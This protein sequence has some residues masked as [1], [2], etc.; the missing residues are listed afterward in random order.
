M[1]I[2]MVATALRSTTRWPI[3]SA[4]TT[5]ADRGAPSSTAGAP[6]VVDPQNGGGIAAEFQPH[7]ALAAR[8]PQP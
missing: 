5:A 4:T 6:H 2:V 1:R 3:D 8:Q 7:V